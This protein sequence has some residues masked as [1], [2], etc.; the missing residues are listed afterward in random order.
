MG[1]R[2]THYAA[3]L[4]AFTLKVSGQSDY[5]FTTNNG[6]I[7]ITRYTGPGGDVVIPDTINGLPVTGIGIDAFFICTKLTTVSIP[8]S[9]TV[10]GYHAFGWCFYLNTVMIGRNVSEIEGMAFTTAMGL[11]ST[12][13]Q[14]IYFLGDAP[15]IVADAFRGNDGA[16]VYYLPWA[17][18][19]GPTLAGRPT[20]PWNPVEW[21]IA[22][23]EDSAVTKP[24]PLLASLSSAWSAIERGNFAAAASQL[25][26]FQHKARS[27]VTDDELAREFIES[28]EHVIDALPQ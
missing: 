24:K 12:N 15:N 25:R 3:L 23:V 13:L 11:S 21:L 8:D 20:A 2:L 28:A 9:V 6:T 17:D 22:M 16:T 7:T 14:S 10:I 19:W 1:M 27:Q 4:L 5:E 18:G 26:A